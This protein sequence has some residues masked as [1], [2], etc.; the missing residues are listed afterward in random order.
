MNV[1]LYH[2][3][4]GTRSCRRR[5]SSHDS[6][7]ADLEKPAALGGIFEETARAGAVP[8][9]FMAELLD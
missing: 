9:P 2:A 5:D 8:A 4:F 3:P 1:A 6:V 7:D